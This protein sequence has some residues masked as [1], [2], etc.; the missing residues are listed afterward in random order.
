MTRKE[1]IAK[2]VGAAMRAVRMDRHESQEA[3]AARIGVDQTVLSKW[4]LGRVRPSLEDIERIEMGLILPP[5]GVLIRAGLVEIPATETE[6]AL[7]SDPYIS[8]EG[9]TALMH[10]YAQE[11]IFTARQNGGRPADRPGATA[12][13]T[14]GSARRSKAKPSGR[15]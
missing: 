13:E 14:T 15:G 3:V 1:E 6:R 2:A 9:R 11:R 12:V 4:E 10:F 7:A 8:T 5:G